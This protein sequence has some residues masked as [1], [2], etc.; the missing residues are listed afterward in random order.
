MIPALFQKIAAA[1]NE[2]HWLNFKSLITEVKSISGFCGASH[3][4][5]DCIFILENYENHNFMLTRY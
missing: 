1:V 4:Y 2:K 3:V 5:Y